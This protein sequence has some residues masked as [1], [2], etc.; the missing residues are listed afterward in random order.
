MNR[1][2]AILLVIVFHLGLN[3]FLPWWNIAI[4]TA[5][6]VW[7]TRLKGF[8]AW[9]IPAFSLS[10]LWGVWILILDQKTGFLISQRVAALFEGKG[11]VAIFIPIIGC[12]I[13]SA[14]SGY[15][16]YLLASSFTKKDE[17]ESLSSD[18]YEMTQPDLGNKEIT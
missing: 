5:L 6:T 14:I 16:A 17:A 13:M 15:T 11:F 2:I 1:I 4:A 9:F 8:G 7:I 12:F 10:F 18:H 3:Y